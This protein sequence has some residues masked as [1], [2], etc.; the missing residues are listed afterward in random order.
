MFISSI[1]ILVYVGSDQI[2]LFPSTS[3]WYLKI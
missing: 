1:M 3:Q 2:R